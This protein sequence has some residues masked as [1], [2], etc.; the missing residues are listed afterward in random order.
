MV[1]DCHVHMRGQ[2]T[3]TPDNSTELLRK[4]KLAGVDGGMIYSNEPLSFHN[5]LAQPGDAK[6]RLEE[7]MAYTRNHDNLHPLFWIDPLEPDAAEQVAMAA[8]AGV[9]GFK[10]ICCHHYPQDE[11]VMPIWQLIANTGK[12]IMFHSGILY[13]N[14]PS[15]NY[16]RPGNFE[17]LFYVKGLRFAMAHISWPWCDEMIAVFGKWNSLSAEKHIAGLADLYVDVTPGTPPIYRRD[18][19][20]KLFTV[21]YEKLPEH[22]MFG[23]DASCIYDH[24]KYARI[25]A[26]DNEIY[27]ELGLSAQTRDQVFSGNMLRFLGVH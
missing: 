27:D 20:T 6:C 9:E 22:V 3:D 26:R 11:R 1:F 14:S 4:M 8:E 7:V 16:N 2:R 12:P 15:A 21:G 10:V 23:T 18:A 5:E 17:H 13:N 19:L 25:I 24:Q